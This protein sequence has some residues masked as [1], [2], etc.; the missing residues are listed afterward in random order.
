ML[1]NQLNS[2]TS[3]L[4]EQQVAKLQ[5]LTA[6]MSAVELSWVSGYLAGISQGGAAALAPQATAA[7]KL[8]VLYGSQTGNAK[9]VAQQV[10]AAA[11]AQGVTVSLVSMGDYKSK[12]LKDETHLLVVVSTNGEGEPPDDAEQLHAFLAGK[13]AP[14][15]DN[16]R[17]AVLGLGDSSYEFFCQTAIDFD[18]RLAALGAQSILP[19]QDCDVDYQGDVDKWQGEALDKVAE[20]LDSGASAQVINLPVGQAAASQ[21][22]KQNPLTASLL[23]SQ[24]ITSRASTKDVRHVEIDLAD[25][26][27]SYQPGDALGVWFDNDPALVVELLSLLQLDGEQNVEVDGKSLPLR[28]ALLSHYELTQLHPGF[29]SSYGEAATIDALTVLA[30]DKPAMRDYIADRQVIDVVREHPTAVSAEQLLAALRRLTPRLYSIASSQAEVEEEVHLTV[31]VVDYQAF[32]EAHQGAASSFLGHRLEEGA[33]VRVYVEDN[34]NFRL[35]DGD[36]PVIMIGPGTGIAPFRAFLQQRDN[37]GAAGDN[38][39]F[40]GNP[41]F[42]DDFLYQVELQD[43]L[44][45]GVLN[46]LDLAFSRDQAEKIYVQDRIREQ[47]AELYQWLERGAHLYICGDGSRMAKDVHQALLEVIQQQGNKDA[48]QAEEYLAALRSDKRYQKDVY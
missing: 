1:L 4:S 42:T 11:E 29:V 20:T 19:R 37:D 15:L 12:Q 34:H 31:G 23:A 44:K 14:K 27:L 2:L 22:T 33:E 21:Y 6:E 3:P 45:R 26:G 38:W 41:H 24:K 9:G 28:E 16:L 39:L 7:G 5:Q 17:Y 43:Y 46:Q 30:D 48:E 47:G 13:R 18:E 35:P 32:G 25:S 8:T 10:A 36:T 40:F